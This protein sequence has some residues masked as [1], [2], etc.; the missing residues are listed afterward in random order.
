[1]SKLVAKLIEQLQ[2][3]IKA[4]E[5]LFISNYQPATK[6]ISPRADRAKALEG[7]Y[8]GISGY[9]GAIHI[10]MGGISGR[11]GAGGITVSKAT[12]ATE[13]K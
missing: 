7:V 8:E 11:F 2:N 12:S 13:V 10:Y 3:A 5:A 9:V 1:M 4:R 6:T